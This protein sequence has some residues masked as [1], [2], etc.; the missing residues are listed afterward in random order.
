MA[1]FVVVNRGDDDR[2]VPPG[3]RSSRIT[4]P[5]IDISSTLL[6]DRVA[7]GVAIRLLTPDAVIAD[8]GRR[9]LYLRST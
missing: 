6:R 9:G 7:E 3:W 2:D 4:I 5:G 8:I 1:E